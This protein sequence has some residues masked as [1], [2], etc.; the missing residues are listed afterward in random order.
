MGFHSGELAVQTR[1][2]V[3]TRAERLAP[4]AAAASSAPPQLTSWRRRSWRS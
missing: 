3:R 1:A 2:G 4:M